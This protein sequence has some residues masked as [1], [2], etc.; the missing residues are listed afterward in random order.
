MRKDDPKYEKHK[1]YM[2]QRVRDMSAKG[3]DIGAIPEVFDSDRRKKCE[4]D[5]RLFLETYFKDGGKFYLGWS[6]D[7]LKIIAKLEEAILQGSLFALAMPRGSGKT[8]IITSAAMWAILYGHRRFVAVIGDGGGAVKEIMA[9]IKTEFENNDLFA[10][11]FP[12]VCYPIRKLEGIVNRSRGQLSEGVRT[13]MTW[14]DDKLI[15]PTTKDNLKT[16][17]SIITCTGITGRIRGMKHTSQQGEALRPDLVLIDDPQ[18]YESAVSQSQTKKRLSILNADVLGL[19]GPGKKIAG[20]MACTVIAKNDLADQILTRDLNPSWQG[21]RIAM[22]KSFPT[23]RQLWNKYSE[24]RIDSLRQH[25]DLR[26]ATKFYKKN[27]KEMDEGAEVY[28][29]ERFVKG[30]ISG[31][32]HAMNLFYHNAEAFASEYQNQP[33]VDDEEANERLKIED[34]FAKIV[35][36]R[37][38]EIPSEAD[39]LVAYIDV[40]KTVLY[41]AVMAFTD[42]MTSHIVDYGTYPDQHRRYYTLADCRETFLTAYPKLGL[43]A[44]IYQALTDCVETICDRQ[45]MRDDG[46][47]MSVERVFIDSAWGKSTDVVFK[48][49][50]ESNWASV[51]VPSRGVAIGAASAP[52]TEYQKKPG[53]KIGDNWIFRKGNRALRHMTYDTYHWKSFTKTRILTAKGEKGS[54]TIFGKEKDIERHRMLAEQLTS[55]YAVQVEGRGRKVDVWKLYLNRDN[56]LWDCVVGCNVAAS[57]LGCSLDVG[58]KANKMRVKTKAREH[59]TRRE[60]RVFGNTGRAF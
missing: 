16:S 14:A 36:R 24:L 31:I 28:W 32:Q 58:D 21:E 2:R 19:A 29:N 12:E 18:N 46:A 13:S 7:H 3:R 39:H 47:E 50:K 35:N 55:E 41:Y 33:A 56:H 30:E 53:E 60:A 48:Y 54:L 1:Q 22:L 11:D 42:G 20:L 23:N 27:R 6:P 45:W 52:I 17:G 25:G 10:E 59:F 26:D 9:D 44:Q 51:V 38:Y 34:V 43:E 8:T 5:L 15:L 40:Q 49:C 37:Q 4:F 57:M